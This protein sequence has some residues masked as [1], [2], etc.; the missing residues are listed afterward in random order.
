MRFQGCSIHCV[1]VCIHICEY[2]YMSMCVNLGSASILKKS[3]LGVEGVCVCVCM[4]LDLGCLATIMLDPVIYKSLNF[5][6]T[7]VSVCA[8]VR[9]CVCAHARNP[10]HHI[11]HYQFRSAF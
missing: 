9:V 3:V 4:W 7:N 2:T 6:D 5:T 10:H 1:C 11:C 8:C